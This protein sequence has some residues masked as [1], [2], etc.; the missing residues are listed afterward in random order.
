MRSGMLAEERRSLILDILEHRGSV[1]VSELH[2]RL[3]VSRETIRR[4]I[5]RLSEDNKLRKTHG[6]ALAN[7]SFEPALAERLEVNRQGKQAIGD[8]AAEMIPN[9]CSVIVDSG[10][11]TV[12]LAEA[13]THHTELTIYTNDLQIA[14]ILL[15]RNGNR[16][17]FIGGELGARDGAAFGS[18]S[19]AMLD[20]YFADFAFIGVSAMSD[21][22][23]IT[24]YTRP[25]A[26]LH[27]M[28]INHSQKAIFLADQTKFNRVAPVRI[29]NANRAALVITDRDPG[30]AIRQSI[31]EL[32][33]D[34]TV[35][36][37]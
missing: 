20:N 5:T 13:L 8:L 27:S 11:T 26:N 16:V 30:E 17:F 10:S 24:D 1:T 31:M 6:G 9:G 33:V 7:D 2:T 14:S 28:M 21:H 34:L 22:P 19:I 37:T 23:W 18:D 4:D 32:G 25:A 35:A 3:K 29:A 36:N 12:W 15:G